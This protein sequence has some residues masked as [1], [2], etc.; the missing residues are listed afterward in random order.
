MND[1]ERAAEFERVLRAVAHSFEAPAQGVRYMRSCWIPYFQGCKQVLDIGC[2]EGVLLELLREA[3]IGAEGIDIDAESV[4]KAKSKGLKVEREWAQ[5]YLAS[6]SGVFDGIFLGHIVEHMPG[7]QLLKFLFDCRQAMKPGG[8][9]IILTPNFQHPNVGNHNFWLDI[10][11]QRPYPLLLL[12]KMYQALGM[13]VVERGLL[14]EQLDEYI[15]GRVRAP[16]ITEID[17]VP[18]INIPGM[19][20]AA[21]PRAKRSRRSTGKP[22]P[23]VWQ[24]GFFNMH[25]LALAN[26]EITLVLAES[27]Q[28]E[29][30]LA[31]TESGDVELAR[32]PR[33]AGLLPLVGRTTDTPPLIHV[34]HGWPPRFDPPEQGHWVM[35]QPWEFGRL[36]QD[37]VAPMRDQVDEIWAYSQFVKQ[38]YVDS[39]V[40][41]EKVFVV[42]LG[43]DPDRFRP[44][45]TPRALKTT[46]SFRFLF[47][48]GTIWRKGI[49]V[50]L[51]A[52][53][54]TFRRKDDVCLVIKDIGMDTFYKG[55]NASADIRRMQE[56][57]DAPEIE[58]ITESIPEDEMPGLYTACQ[59]F[60]HP[61]R[62][63][64]FG[65]PVA[66][67]MASG[68]AVIVSR[69]G[70]CDDFC[71]EDTVFFTPAF[72]QPMN[73]FV[74]MVG[75][76]WALEPDLSAL[77][78][79]MR[80]VVQD[81]VGAAA[82]GQRASQWVR[83]NLTWEASADAALARLR[84]LA[85]VPQRERKIIVAMAK[86]SSSSQAANVDDPAQRAAILA[87]ESGRD[88]LHAGDRD[89]AETRLRQAILRAPDLAAAHYLLASISVEKENLNEALTGFMTAVRLEPNRT[90]FL[91]GLGAVLQ[92]LNRNEEAR[93][94]YRRALTLDPNNVDAR[95]NLASL[96]AIP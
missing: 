9:M 71:R 70:A 56:D 20:V 40:P 8:V 83:E 13:N 33:L 74:P 18:R 85:R 80:Y 67:A 87:Y 11:H 23:V 50:L 17:G 22:V 64:G 72:R 63:E 47:V 78:S 25:S 65:L 75:Q 81:P 1:M 91:N 79:Q 59:C 31:A 4:A 32:D 29:L 26:R 30:A 51:R 38:V 92:E 57:S 34:R 45:V 52:Y 94:W 66:E 61:Y 77:S 53:A 21:R 93:E 86:H 37:W 39:G 54:G 28:V 90:H 44:D 55:Q 6:R 46:K 95:E 89:L 12:E 2:G 88:A 58:Y 84:A 41:A 16:I 96:E 62:G 14:V 27:G 69:G 19:T 76:P 60:V 24:G 7:D 10:T 5:D 73:P 82:R 15:V 42:Q 3:G 68:Q 36:P 43:V 49:D 48:G 35:I